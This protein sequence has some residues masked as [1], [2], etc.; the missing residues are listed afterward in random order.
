MRN[1]PVLPP[2][3]DTTVPRC[4]E[5]VRILRHGA[6][7]MPGL[8][9]LRTWLRPYIC[10]LDLILSEIPQGARHYDLGCGTGGLLYLS[11]SLRG[12][13]VAHGSDVSPEVV[14]A[15]SAFDV[16]KHRFAVTLLAPKTTRPDLSAYDTITMVD[17]LHHVP[18]AHQSTFLSDLV[19]NLAPGA[20][21][22]LKD[23]DAGKPLGAWCNQ[24][25][26]LLFSREWVHHRRSW[27]VAQW[28]EHAG[29]QVECLIQRWTW[30]YPH[31]LIVAMK[32][33]SNV[34][35]ACSR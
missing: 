23:I 24:L 31:F 19:S 33:S 29:M 16:D 1:A 26:D 14:T 18:A 34:G 8:L 30:W 28:L 13:Q 6:R 21:L 25:H 11:L 3:T 17:V 9:G 12:A 22:I 27:E 2:T 35:D 32:P 4:G 10:P 20:K 5:L 7:T 15:A